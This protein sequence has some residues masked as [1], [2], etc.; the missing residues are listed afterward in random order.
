MCRH[1]LETLERF[2]PVLWRLWIQWQLQGNRGRAHSKN[3]YRNMRWTRTRAHPDCQSSTL[4]WGKLR[5]FTYQSQP[6][7]EFWYTCVWQSVWLWK[8][9]RHQPLRPVY[10]F[11]E[12]G[13]NCVFSILLCQR[14]LRLINAHTCL[15]Q[16]AKLSGTRIKYKWP[17]TGL[18]VTIMS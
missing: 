5:P 7:Q 12:W 18:K 10:N 15:S 17:L 4:F 13:F 6:N 14:M 16:I 8:I 3:S 11:Q 2:R 9:F 1:K